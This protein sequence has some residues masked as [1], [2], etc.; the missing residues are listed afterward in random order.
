[1]P[2]VVYSPC[3]RALENTLAADIKC[4]AAVGGIATC[5]L[6]VLASACS[7]QPPQDDRGGK[8]PVDVPG[9]RQASLPNKAV[10]D[11]RGNVAVLSNSVKIIQAMVPKEV[12]DGAPWMDPFSDPRKEQFHVWESYGASRARTLQVRVKKMKDAREVKGEISRERSEMAGYIS[13]KKR[14][15]VVAGA[16]RS[17]DGVGA[18]CLSYSL[19]EYSVQPMR[20]DRSRLYRVAGASLFCGVRNVTIAIQWQGMDY[21]S[22][23]D[24]QRGK[25]LDYVV[26]K[27]QAIAMMK[28]IVASYSPGQ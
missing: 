28:A 23:W 18:E 27:Q 20:G 10:L 7:S 11:S 22:P 2:Q 4:V 3:W 19:D 16:A 25:G 17:V 15:K 14:F 12:A 6:A 24:T 9:T 8:F 1:V 26:S 21:S 13:K 5:A